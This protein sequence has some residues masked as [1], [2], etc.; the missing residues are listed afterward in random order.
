MQVYATEIVHRNRWILMC[1]IFLIALVALG[2][3]VSYYYVVTE[4]HPSYS[5]YKVHCK[6]LY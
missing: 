4:T 3:V 6:C 2:E 1:Y 5:F